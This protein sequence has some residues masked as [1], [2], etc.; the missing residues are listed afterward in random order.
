MKL[1]CTLSS[2]T[3]QEQVTEEKD[4]Y[5]SHKS[6]HQGK[7]ASANAEKKTEYE[8]VNPE[9]L[10]KESSFNLEQQVADASLNK[11]NHDK[12][13]ALG[14][15]EIYINIVD[16]YYNKTWRV[17]YEAFDENCLDKKTF[18]DGLLELH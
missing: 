1:K 16:E 2:G 12:F 3:S 6:K 4:E 15:F 8:I 17:I 18:T 11:S 9:K 7:D 10:Q 13:K 14:T 5:S